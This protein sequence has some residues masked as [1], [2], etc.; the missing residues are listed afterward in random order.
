MTFTPGG[1]G[2]EKN[3]H[4]PHAY[5]VIFEDPRKINPPIEIFLD[6][7]LTELNIVDTLLDK[8]GPC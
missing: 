6:P 7:P 1:E 4:A 8:H 2:K 3:S 5:Q